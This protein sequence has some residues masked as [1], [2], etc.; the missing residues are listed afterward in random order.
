MWLWNKIL[1]SA[2]SLSMLGSVS[3][4]SVDT[5]AERTWE[6]ADSIENIEPENID[7]LE[8]TFIPKVQEEAQKEISLC[9]T[10]DDSDS[11][12]YKKDLESI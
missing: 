1:A 12:T 10:Q 11:F 8:S 5:K 2:V 6:I 7:T 9:L 3:Q 4:C